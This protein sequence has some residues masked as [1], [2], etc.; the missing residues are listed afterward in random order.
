MT[1]PNDHDL[2]L[3]IKQGDLSSYEAIFRKYYAALARYAT[4]MVRNQDIGEDITQEVFMYIWE[5]RDRIEL[6]GELKSYLFSSVKNKCLNYIKLELPRQQ[7]LTDLSGVSEWGQTDMTTDETELL[8][9]KIQRAIDQLPKKCQHIFVL[10]RYGGLTYNEIADEL[11]LSA[12]T[13]ENQMSI[14][15]KKLKEMLS[16]EIKDFGIK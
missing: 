13:V 8:R 6:H 14:A 7:A 9:K 16:E 3:Q 11:D 10:S 5:K 1:E 12:K 15:L 2:F 4:S